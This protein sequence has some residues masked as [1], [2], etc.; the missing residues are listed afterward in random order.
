MFMGRGWTITNRE[1]TNQTVDRIF[2][3][4]PD[5]WPKSRIKRLINPSLL[6]DLGRVMRPM[7]LRIASDIA[8]YQLRS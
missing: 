7:L 2:I 3:L 5:P 8:D 4:F 6:R 1:L